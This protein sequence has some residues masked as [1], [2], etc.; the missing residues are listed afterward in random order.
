M[1][2]GKL[3]NI[4]KLFTGAA[5]LTALLSSCATT[6]TA[7]VDTKDLSYLYNP[8]RNPVN[9]RYI[10][11][12]ESE[13]KAS[14]GVKFFANELFF[15]GSQSSGSANFVHD[16]HHQAFQYNKGPGAG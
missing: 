12:T 16:H 5:L 1:Y 10:I 9:P 14:L 6:K 2:R 7:P 8:I 4:L 3:L 13:N 11:T 15:L